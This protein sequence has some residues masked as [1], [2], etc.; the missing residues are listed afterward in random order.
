[1][2]ATV[3][4]SQ[5]VNGDVEADTS[6]WAMFVYKNTALMVQQIILTVISALTDKP[7]TMD[8]AHINKA[9]Q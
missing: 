7:T 5:I 3:I 8:N 4:M 1:M 6:K 2:V 9:V